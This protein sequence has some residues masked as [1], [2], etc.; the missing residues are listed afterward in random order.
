MLVR[1]KILLIG[2]ADSDRPRSC[3]DW[4]KGVD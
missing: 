1:E 2:C 3:E 4:D